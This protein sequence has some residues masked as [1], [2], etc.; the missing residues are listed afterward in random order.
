MTQR[1]LFA[2]S[3]VFLLIASVDAGERKMTLLTSLDVTQA[4]AE[5]LTKDTSFA[6]INVIPQGYSMRGH[7]AFLK[8][9][10]TAFFE[11]AA[12][13]EA[14]LIV[15][16]AWPNDP[17]YKWARRGNIRIVAIDAAKPLDGYGASVPLIEVQGRTSP[18]V[19][20]SPAN[21]T[22][23]AS[24]VAD[25]LARLSPNDAETV[26]S[27]LQRLQTALFALRSKYE[28]AF[29]KLDFVDLAA[30]TPDYAYLADEFG[31]D[32]RFHYLKQETA[33]SEEGMRRLSERLV[34]ETI[35]AVICPW[36]PGEKGRS[37]LSD[38]GVTPV[39]LKR[40]VRDAESG[41]LDDLVNWYE[42]NLSA[43]LAG[44]ETN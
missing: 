38:T 3:A 21:L 33:W 11:T 15:S 4:M 42:Y 12:D 22:R 30:F 31:L 1:L 2:F 13:A 43:L 28:L 35:R 34:S 16:S 17:L 44:L 24:I 20:R 9:R 5:A 29:S 32:V 14:A 19:W 37:V 18:F 10:Q 40:F 27:N 26:K 6:V 36:E 25:D 39:V 8:K 7:D 23:M 41:S